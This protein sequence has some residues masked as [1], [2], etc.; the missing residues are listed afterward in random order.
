ML[1]PIKR[2]HRTLA[3]ARKAVEGYQGM[4]FNALQ[5]YKIKGRVNKYWV[6][7][8]LEWRIRRGAC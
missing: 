7:S 5:V 6:G 4:D 2:L 3:S 1:K 8:D